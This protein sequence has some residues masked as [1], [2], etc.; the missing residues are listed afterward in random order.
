[1]PVRSALV[2]RF[3]GVEPM[4]LRL[5]NDR[6]TATFGEVPLGGSEQG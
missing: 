4:I 2:E 6:A 1:M 3:G 5:Q